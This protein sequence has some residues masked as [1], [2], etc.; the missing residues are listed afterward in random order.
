MI[1]FPDILV[2]K[3]AGRG[4]EFV[5]RDF[6]DRFGVYD[7][8]LAGATRRQRWMDAFRHV[9]LKGTELNDLV[10]FF[11]RKGFTFSPEELHTVSLDVTLSGPPELFVSYNRQDQL[12]ARKLAHSLV[13]ENQVRVFFDEISISPGDVWVEKL[14]IA[15]SSCKTAAVCIGKHGMGPWQREEFW[16]ILA[17]AVGGATTVIP[18]L[19]EGGPS[20]SELPVFL[21]SRHSVDL[22][23]N[24]K[25]G[26]RLIAEVVSDRRI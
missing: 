17:E 5:L 8:D 3:I 15:I 26:V 7:N 20:P 25:D 16:S 10:A 14:A 19:F 4:E 1:I 23:S 22:R 2:T 11:E 13:N 24:W 9:A 18:V 12:F 6:L 21:R